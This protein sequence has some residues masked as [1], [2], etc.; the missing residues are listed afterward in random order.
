M[1]LETDSDYQL[2][3]TQH[4]SDGV[5]QNTSSTTTQVRAADTQNHQTSDSTGP[6]PIGHARR[7]SLLS[8][9]APVFTPRKGL[10]RACDS[11][12]TTADMTYSPTGSPKAS[13]TAP[14]SVVSGSPLDD[15]SPL[16]DATILKTIVNNGKNRTMETMARARQTQQR[17]L[18][19]MDR[20]VAEWTEETG[21]F[22]TDYQINSGH[23]RS[24]SSHSFDNAPRDTILYQSNCEVSP[25]SRNV[26]QVSMP[27]YRTT[28]PPLF[29]L[30]GTKPGDDSSI[31]L[32][33]E[34]EYPMVN[35]FAGLPRNQ[36]GSHPH[37]SNSIRM[38]PPPAPILAPA[39]PAVPST[40]NS[41]LLP[42]LP[43]R[44]SVHVHVHPELLK[45]TLN[46]AAGK[47]IWTVTA[48]DQ[49]M[50][51]TSQHRRVSLLAH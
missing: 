19:Y 22:S 9:T 43:R 51:R 27:G 12:A 32:P 40:V 24:S 6:R 29:Q 3:T 5:A 36:A 1:S 30:P 26:G 28:S 39:T 10:H 15:Y 38:S 4:K 25:T 34:D 49:D 18:E 41:T 16:S 13:S 48:E 31:L 46:F 44:L 14:T 37:R 20:K 23:Q 21:I 42:S 2:G 33:F 11:M 45:D 50:W 47:T 7:A 8:A 17:Y 35:Y